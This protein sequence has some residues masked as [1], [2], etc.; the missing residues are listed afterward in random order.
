MSILC[1]LFNWIPLKTCLPKINTAWKVSLFVVFLVCI[2]SECGEIWT[3][4]ILNTDTFYAV[5]CLVFLRYVD[6]IENVVRERLIS[7]TEVE[8][9]SGKYFVAMLKNCL[10]VLDTDLTARVNNSTDCFKYAR[11][12]QW[13]FFTSLQT[14]SH[15]SLYLVLCP[16]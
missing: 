4:K 2:Q 9:L 7:M 5:Q 11:Y 15:T 16:Y 3:R 10:S 13:T 14:A 8:N 1:F 12:I 6:P